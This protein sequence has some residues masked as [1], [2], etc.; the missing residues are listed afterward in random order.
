MATTAP[1][2]EERLAQLNLTPPNAEWQNK[3]ASRRTG[4]WLVEARNNGLTNV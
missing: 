4:N 1:S 2:I 3:G